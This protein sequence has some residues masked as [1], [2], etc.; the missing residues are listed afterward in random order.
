[1]LHHEPIIMKAYVGEYGEKYLTISNL[2]RVIEKLTENSG[3]SNLF[4]P[5]CDV[6][7]TMEHV[8]NLLIRSGYADH[9]IKEAVMRFIDNWIKGVNGEELFKTL[10]EIIA[11]SSVMGDPDTL[12]IRRAKVA[13][14]LHPLV[15]SDSLAANII[16]G[17]GCGRYEVDEGTFITRRALDGAEFITDELIQ[18]IE[19]LLK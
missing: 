16:R 2:K 9:S 13:L 3:S 6:K 10:K 15:V 19:N 12:L 18:V 14:L 1:M 4:R 8:T 17:K 7:T 11:W 5:N